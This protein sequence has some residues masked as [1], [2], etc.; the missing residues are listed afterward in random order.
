[1]IKHILMTLTIAGL[2][3]ASPMLTHAT[4]IDFEGLSDSD[5]VTVQFPGLAGGPRG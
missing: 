4:G 5:Q 2:L 1:M 3:I